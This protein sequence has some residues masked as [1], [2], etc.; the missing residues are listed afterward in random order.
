MKIK[1]ISLLLAF[2]AI[3][4]C[5]PAQET[6]LH[7]QF[8]FLG[9][10]MPEPQR[11]VRAVWLT[12]LSGLDWP[13]RTARNESGAIRQKK[14]LCDILDKLQA[15]G[16]NTVIFQTRIRS[17][18]SYP[19]DIEPWDGVFTGTPGRK[20]PY[21]P[22]QFALDECHKRGMELHA[23]VVAFPICK[24]PVAKKLGNKALP[25]V[26]PELCQRCGDQW[27]M[28][29][30]VPGTDDYIARICK[31]IV[32]R[33]NVDGIHLDYIRYPE[34]GISF[35]DNK[36]FKKYGKGKN[37]AAWRR[38][39]VTRCVRK[40]HQAVK[41]VRPWV[42]LSCSPVGKYADLPRQSSYGW[43]ARDAVSQDAQAWL[44]DGL[45]DMLF[46]MM[47][48][49]GKHFYPFALDWQENS[50]GGHI[51]PGLGIYFMHPREKD[52]DLNVI[53]RQMYFLR[54][55]GLSGEAFFRSKFFTDNVKGI[56]DFCADD[57][58]HYPAL[59]PAITR[60]DAIP[61]TIP[62][63]AI[64]KSGKSLS[65]CWKPS[66]DN[67]PNAPVYYLVYR[68]R[69]REDGLD[70][71]TLLCSKMSDTRF[72]LT[73][74]SPNGLNATYAVTAIDAF[75]NESAPAILTAATE[76]SPNLPMPIVCNRLELP[77]ADHA[78][79]VLIKDIT[80]KHVLT[81]RYGPHIDISPLAKGFY[82][83]RTLNK[84]GH[85]HRLLYFRKE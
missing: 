68:L 35:N 59:P 54:S 74:A 58:Y 63:A 81:R 32:T 6:L 10:D 30:G 46:P 53:R 62:D 51:V 14:E 49:D 2:T 72:T 80:G 40:I 64:S 82:E 7:R 50:Y 45:M 34:R 12:T 65:L 71:A 5:L 48:F 27:M 75:G 24:V 1:R 11:E 43:N 76:Y 42:K 55:A 38:E 56:Y 8:S 4:L 37:K 33:Y 79:F 13:S 77:T 60:I 44:R 28:D 23:W 26:R 21:D 70:G 18:T 19:S 9:T 61:P 57:F 39:N 41:S 73:P 47:Y 83:A 85:S 84:K 29:P 22:L 20:P 31:E 16:I 52:W 67:T 17:T 36:T 69:D 66:T 78:E 3:T 15:G 25:K